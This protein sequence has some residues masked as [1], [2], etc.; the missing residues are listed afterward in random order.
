MTESKFE[1]KTF[2]SDIILKTNEP[3][4]LSKDVLRD[5][6]CTWLINFASKE[7]PV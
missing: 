1:L 5:E 4:L 6:I 3:N 2:G 7:D